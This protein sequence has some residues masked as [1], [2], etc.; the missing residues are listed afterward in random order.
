MF[1]KVQKKMEG[2]SKALCS[3]CK[4]ISA[5]AAGFIAESGQATWELRK[6]F[7]FVIFLTML[8]KDH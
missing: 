5:K 4:S 6:S 2:K 1:V 8:K 7:F 3:P